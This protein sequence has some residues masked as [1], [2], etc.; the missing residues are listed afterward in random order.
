MSYLFI[1]KIS[2]KEKSFYYLKK[3]KIRKNPKTNFSGFFRFF[4]VDFLLPTLPPGRGR[5]AARE[6][7][8]TRLRKSGR[9][10][11]RQP[12]GPRRNAQWPQPPSNCYPTD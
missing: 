2:F 9:G 11:G 1:K 6:T 5:A 10:Q 7:A 8:R 4:W 12:L 3:I